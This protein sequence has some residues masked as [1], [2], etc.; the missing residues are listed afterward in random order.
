MGPSARGKRVENVLDSLPEPLWSEDFAVLLGFKK[1][2]LG[3]RKDV[4]QG[5]ELVRKTMLEL[6]F[7]RN[8]KEHEI[9]QDLIWSRFCALYLPALVDRF[10]DPWTAT[11]GSYIEKDAS[12][13]EDYQLFNPWLRMLVMVQHN[14]YLGKYLRSRKPVSSGNQHLTRVLGQRLSHVAA[15]WDREIRKP[16]SDHQE[17]YKGAAADVVQ[18]LSTL[19]TTFVSSRD[20]EKIL[21]A[22][23]KK[24]L[25]PFLSGW[26]DLFYDPTMARGDEQVSL[27]DVCFRTVIQLSSERDKRPQVHQYILKVKKH[28][29]GWDQCGLP[30]CAATG[31][32]KACGRCHTVKYCGSDHQTLHWKWLSGPHKEMCFMTE[33]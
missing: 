13:R 20:S 32:M 16:A 28:L 19:L 2:A 33:F 17:Y 27:G 31:D 6:Y 10:L 4:L 21:P 9:Q 3:P 25:L 12:A 1:S 14:P 22:D 8:S 23:T 15:R 30:T 29:K 7:D 18:L 24:K 5:D 26:R 11:D